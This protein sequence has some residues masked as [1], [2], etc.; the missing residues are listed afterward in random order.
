MPTEFAKQKG[1]WW[2]PWQGQNSLHKTSHK[3]YIIQVTVTFTV[4]FHS[5][6]CAIG[7]PY[8][9]EG[10]IAVIIM[11]ANRTLGTMPNDFAKQI[12]L[13]WIPWLGQN[14]LC[15]TSQLVILRLLAIIF[16]MNGTLG[17]MPN[18]FAKQKGLW[19]VPWPKRNELHKTS[20]QQCIYH[21]FYGPSI[22][23][24]DHKLMKTDVVDVLVR[25]EAWLKWL[26]GCAQEVPQVPQLTKFCLKVTGKLLFPYK[27]KNTH[28]AP[29]I[30]WL[31]TFGLLE[32]FS[33]T[34][35]L[36][37]LMYEFKIEE[38]P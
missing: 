11:L 35:A 30:S 10:E 23:W 20:Q 17:K 16:L 28:W 25:T 6:I 24:S 4:N 32:I 14:E 3:Q 1:L 18:E 2:I 12:S 9:I 31:R 13:W 7:N 38:I 36:H 5:W 26:Q 21:K 22:N 15:K 37:G 27:L 34:T 33:Y 29:T 8:A 19:W